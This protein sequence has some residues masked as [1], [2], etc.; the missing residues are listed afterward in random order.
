MLFRS[1]RSRELNVRLQEAADSQLPSWEFVSHTIGFEGISQ[2]K[3]VI[4]EAGEREK[5]D[6]EALL[7][8]V[9]RKCFDLVKMDLTDAEK[10]RGHS[11]LQPYYDDIDGYEARWAAFE[12]LL[13][14]IWLVDEVVLRK[15]HSICGPAEH[16][17]IQSSG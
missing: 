9:A 10:S 4:Q 11:P 5:M 15:V 12:V 14:S 7:E 16:L 2:I 6:D 17:R 3:K 1:S 8:Q 13:R